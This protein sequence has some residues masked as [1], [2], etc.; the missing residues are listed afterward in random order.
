MASSVLNSLYVDTKCTIFVICCLIGI[1][2]RDE[3]NISFYFLNGLGKGMAD[4]LF[5]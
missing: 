5:S 4:L 2:N 3:G 1:R